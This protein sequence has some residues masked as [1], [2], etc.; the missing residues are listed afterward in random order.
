MRGLGLAGE[1]VEYVRDEVLES[2]AISLISPAEESLEEFYGRHDYEPHFFAEERQ[3]AGDDEDIFEFDEEDKEYEKFEPA[4]EMKSLDAEEYN[5]KREAFLEERPHVKL[6]DSFMELIYTESLRPDGSSGLYEING[7]D[8]L[9]A[10]AEHPEVGVFIAELIINPSLAKISEE[11]DVEIARSIAC[12]LGI[13]LIIYRT[14]GP[15]KCQ[16]MAAG[17]ENASEAYYGFPID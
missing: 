13:D 5:R 4:L 11:I 14:P 16:S 6:S 17:I 2:G 3:V 1:L 10:I 9:C 12:K 8:A 7:G 15:G